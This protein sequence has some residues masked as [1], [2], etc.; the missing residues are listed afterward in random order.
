MGGDGEKEI[1]TLCRYSRQFASGRGGIAQS[2]R[3]RVFG[4]GGRWG[5]SHRSKDSAV[6]VG[7]IVFQGYNFLPSA[8]MTAPLALGLIG[9]SRT[10]NQY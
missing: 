7:V 9:R 6:D 4:R 1:G 3:V 10:E 5:S 8:K 2:V